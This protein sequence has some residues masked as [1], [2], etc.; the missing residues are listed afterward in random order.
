MT[1]SI[2]KEELENI[3]SE[4]N[5]EMDGPVLIINIMKRAFPPKFIPK[6]GQ[7]VAVSDK[8]ICFDYFGTFEGMNDSGKYICADAGWDNA[9]ALTP[10]EKGE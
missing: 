4:T 5:W 2:T 1:E 8:D 9:R 3:M 6:V 10:T 7:V